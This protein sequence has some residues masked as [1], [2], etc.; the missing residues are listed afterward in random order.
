MHPIKCFDNWVETDHPYGTGASEKIILENP[1]DG[2][3]GIFKFPKTFDDGNITGEYWAE[4]LACEIAKLIDI[5]CADVDIGIYNGRYGSMSYIFVKED[6]SESLIEGINFILSEYPTYDRYKFKDIKTG[7]IYSVQ[8]IIK[9]LQF[10][11]D[12]PL[13]IQSVLKILV[14]DCLIGNSDRHPNNWGL[15]LNTET[16]DISIAPMY[17]NGSSLC[18]YVEEE[19][20]DIHFI[21]HMKFNSLVVTKAFS[22]V[23]WEDKRKIRHFELLHK[24][25]KYYYDQTVDVVGK[26]ARQLS[27]NV[28]EYILS[29]FSDD[30]ISI[31]MKKLLLEYLNAKRNRI[32]DIYDWREKH[33]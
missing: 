11:F 24:I 32:L 5:P 22:R 25:K 2:K 19:A 29:Q 1:E 13:V 28:L 15:I 16:L 20:I 26:I 7:T 18:S 6:S 9:S 31:N 27:Y 33:D 17:D 10:L 23:G 4:K 30:I 3:K 21:D 8:M 12:A 14:F